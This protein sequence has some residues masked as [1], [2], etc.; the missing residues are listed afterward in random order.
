MFMHRGKSRFIGRFVAACQQLLALGV[1]FAVLAP[2]TSIISL[3]VVSG[4]EP[5]AGAPAARI[6]TTGASAVESRAVEAEVSE[7]SLVDPATAA[8]DSVVSEP[9]PVE[10]YGA[11]GVTWSP[12]DMVDDEEITLQARTQT[13][14][15]WSGWADL[16]YH[17]EHGP[18][19]DSAEAKS[20]RP[21]T[22]PLLI[23]N[24]DEVQ[25]RVSV[26][27]SE[28]AVPAG[29]SLAV[30][31]PGESDQVTQTPSIDTARLDAAG[32]GDLRVSD[33][34]GDPDLLALS[35]GGS[36]PKPKIYSRAQW[37]ADES[38]RSASSL[39][40]GEVH[41][42]FVHHTV[43]A[44][45]YTRAEV[46]GIIR[47]IYAY[48]TRSRGWSDVGYNFLI[49]RFGRIWEGRYGGVHRPVVGAH[50]LNYNDY[51]FAG[52]AIGNFETATPSSALLSAY[53][54][55]F[56][57]KLSLHGVD[58][59]STS[60]RVGKR[61]FPAINGHRDAAATACPGR[62]LYA[63]LSSIRSLAAD[64]QA[65]W[66]GRQLDG[67]LVKSEHPD[68]V[69]RRASDQ[70]AYIVATGGLTRFRAPVTSSTGWASMTAV[71]A[72]PDLTGDGRA[73]LVARNAG[74]TTRVYPGDGAGKFSSGI[75]P[76]TKFKRVTLIT[77]AGD[78]N[79]DRRNDL[80]AVRRSDDRL[81]AYLGRG[82]G[83]FDKRLLPQ[84]LA[85]YDL[86]TG[87]GDVTG[88]SRPDL[89]GRD[90]D[91]RLYIHR[92]GKL[93]QRIA[94]RGTYTSLDSIAG[95][96]DYTRDG[97]ADLVLRTAKKG[98]AYVLPSRGDGTFGHLIGPLKSVRGLEDITSG[99][100]TTGFRTP[101]L[102]ARSGDRLVVVASRGTYHSSR[103]IAT[104]TSLASSDL[105]L[106]VGDW[107]GDGNGDL[108][109]RA[110]S[111]GSLELRRGNG[112]G[113]FVA[114]VTLGTGFGSVSHLAA[115][116]DMT[117]DGNPDLMGQPAGQGMRIY[118][119]RGLSG[120]G[121]SYG[122]AGAISVDRYFGVGRWDT[123]G[124]PDALARKGDT[125]KV[126][127]G[128]GPGGL[129]GSRTLSL[130]ISG[131]DWV[132]GIGNLRGKAHPGLIVR[133]AKTGDLWSIAATASRFAKPR[134]LAE[135]FEGYDLI[136]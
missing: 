98:K 19:P 35:A 52:A 89:V 94:I 16:E 31:T 132:G 62:N 110:A 44:N 131:Y 50:T 3:E 113:Q 21:G 76:T 32:G 49:D 58:P 73:D 33:E 27:G 6:A 101:D 38:Q 11:V 67:D 129:T 70:M 124:A 17:D 77:A 22:D 54:A 41:A 87:A 7:V 119:G 64:A 116:G 111:T 83:R 81:V 72:S 127:L 134:F 57:W 92:G 8:D 84:V 25:V 106:N 82:K 108:V 28:V 30:I 20:A 100:Q 61:D 55:L 95:F 123:D 97:R 5:T 68:I 29:L 115:V 15:T 96:G 10:G 12:R 105:L 69:A 120:L 117:G 9:Q 42:G 47:S 60:Q 80:V 133:N 18:D 23:G 14:G 78:L 86:L 102:V 128:N 26:A 130:D 126:Y 39:H 104:G 34:A 112:R 51:A 65:G 36:T 121:V 45:D 75:R 91:G 136:G 118:P 85:G 4:T 37:G 88:D 107:D 48:H 24:V 2:A 63:K 66:S 56:A 99:G 79:R 1:V 90:S 13:A 114:P 53:G 46:P 125:L 40:Y 103:P 135:S 74:G 93:S 109:T 59:A 71:V 43:N 122:A